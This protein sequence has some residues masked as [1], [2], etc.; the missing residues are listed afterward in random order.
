MTEIVDQGD[1]DERHEK[2]LAFFKRVRDESLRRI[3]EVMCA[4][5][6]K[7]DNENVGRFAH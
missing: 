1:T 3:A 7:R 5:E 6:P 2:A 4:S